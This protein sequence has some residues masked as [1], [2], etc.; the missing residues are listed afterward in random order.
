[1][2]ITV[3]NAE[4][5]DAIAGATIDV[6]GGG[7]PGSTLGKI[8]GSETTDHDGMAAIANLAYGYD[9]SVEKDGYATVA[10]TIYIG[11]HKDIE[12]ELEPI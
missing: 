12:I 7:I 5:G 11:R 1:M 10:R 9:L 4:T 6:V 2:T 3:T 8:L